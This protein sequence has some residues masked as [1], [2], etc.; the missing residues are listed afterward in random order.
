MTIAM[1]GLAI[2]GLTTGSA[3]HFEIGKAIGFKSLRLNYW[4]INQVI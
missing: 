4:E 2:T 1:I 3:S